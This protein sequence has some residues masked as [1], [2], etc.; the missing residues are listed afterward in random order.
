MVRASPATR[1]SRPVCPGHE[2]SC[3]TLLPSLTPQMP[4]I[5]PTNARSV[6]G[7]LA[8]VDVHSSSMIRVACGMHSV[9]WTPTRT[10]YPMIRRTNPMMEHAVATPYATVH[11]AAGFRYQPFPAQPQFTVHECTSGLMSAIVLLPS[12]SGFDDTLHPTRLLSLAR[13]TSSSLPPLPRPRA[14]STLGSARSTRV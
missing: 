8:T 3:V 10:T 7:F 11:F 5:Y 2:S 14:S 1:V 9:G 13:R 12:A 6:S 4:Q